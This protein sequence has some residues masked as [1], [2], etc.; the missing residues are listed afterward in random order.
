MTQSITF[1]DDVFLPSFTCGGVYT[2]N[3]WI[4]T[5]DGSRLNTVYPEA[6]TH[7]TDREDYIKITA[8]ALSNAPSGPLTLKMYGILTWESTDY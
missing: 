4:E 2:Q 3:F 5:S 7:G 6:S 1:P 8:G